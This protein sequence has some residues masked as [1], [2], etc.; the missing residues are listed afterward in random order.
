MTRQTHP[1]PFAKTILPDRV[2]G[3]DAAPLP[4]PAPFPSTAA[5]TA[6]P[7]VFAGADCAG[8]DAAYADM[9]AGCHFLIARGADR[10][11]AA[12]PPVIA[13]RRACN[14]LKE[15]DRFLVLMIDASNAG[16][17]APHGTR[18]VYV[19]EGDAALRLGRTAVL[20]RAFALDAPRLRAIGRIRA[21]AT[22]DAPAEA[23][24]RPRAD[25]A[26][27]TMGDDP[28]D[29]AR[30]APFV[31]GDRVLA[32]IAAYYLSLAER[33]HAMVSGAVPLMQ[34]AVP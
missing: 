21:L 13:V 1:A 19:R 10:D 8:L 4:A 20:R 9:I 32:A 25:L 22:G 30:H 23:G 14:C 28:A 27:A 24:S 33:L 26:L 11:C 16:H 15:L 7:A 6:L 31:L 18:T 5:P 12:L 29:Q 3:H 34:G 17:A 2:T